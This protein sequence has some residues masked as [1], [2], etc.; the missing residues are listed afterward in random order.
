MSELAELFDSLD[1]E[2]WFDREGVQH[3]ITHGSSGM[4]INAK[5][6]PFC[7]DRRWRV[8]LNAETGAGNCFLCGEK[9]SKSKFIHQHIGG[10]WG[11]T[12]QHVKDVLHDQ[13]W[14]PKRK[15]KVATEN[16]NDIQIPESLP[17]PTKDGQMLIYLVERGITP[18]LAEYFGLRFCIDA[19]WNYVR[20]DGEKGGQNFANRVLIPI[21][22]LDGTLVNFQGRDVTGGEDRRKYLFPAGLPGTGR[23]LYNAHNGVRM[24]RAVLGEGVF[25]VIAIKKA[26][27]EDVGLRDVAPMASFGKHLSYG[28]LD[29]NDQLGRFLK[30][31]EMGLEEV[32]IMWDGEK[33]ALVSAIATA[34]KIRGIGL[35]VRI[36]LLPA[37]KDPNEASAEEVRAAFYGARLYDKM[38]GVAWLLRNPYK[39]PS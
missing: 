36:A 20:D 8:Y 31:K 18:E 21:H 9:F 5:E 23:F 17:M 32:T 15:N 33:N 1:M 12:I 28:A 24:K 25:D 26:F 10:A 7:G 29:G 38:A 19:W 27:D 11:P 39:L 4:Q 13:G 16:P 3:K 22:D 14:R 6:C 34:D 2:F 30:L 37:G 35:K